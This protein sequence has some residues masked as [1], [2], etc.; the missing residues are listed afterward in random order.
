MSARRNL[1]GGWYCRD[2]GWTTTQLPSGMVT[3]GRCGALGLNGFDNDRPEHVKCGLDGCL[4]LVWIDGVEPRKWQHK[5][6]AV[7]V[8]AS[9]EGG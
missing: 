7:R 6:H 1:P 4:Q 2:C 3:C 8:P 9:T 5:R